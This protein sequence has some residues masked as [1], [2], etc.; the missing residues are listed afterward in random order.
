MPRV[1]QSLAQLQKSIG[2]QFADESLLRLALRH[3]SSGKPNN[4]RLEFLGDAI[5]NAV[6][7]ELLYLSD[8]IAAEGEMTVVRSK[9]VNGEALSGL[10][11]QLKLD[12]MLEL[13]RGERAVGTVKNSIIEDAFE[14]IVGAI[15]LDSSFTTAREVILELLREK[16]LALASQDFSKDPKSELQ[17]VMQASGVSLPKY[18]LLKTEGP[19]H[20]R[21]FTVS[22]RVPLAQDTTEASG[23]SRRLAERRA[24]A[25]MLEQLKADEGR[26][27]D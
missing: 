15:F 17:E 23:S 3:K 4:E 12:T 6:V 26:I 11:R 1:Q 2:Y 16:V 21:E 19:D 20:Q 18:R 10:G 24:A 22:C 14:A 25:A 13:G 5:L 27:P 7:A 9:L 8:D